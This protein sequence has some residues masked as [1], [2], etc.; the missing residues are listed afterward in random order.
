MLCAG[1]ESAPAVLFP[2]FLVHA[3]TH[4]CGW[5]LLFNFL[6]CPGEG[7]RG[8]IQ[9]R[10]RLSHP[11]FLSDLS[12]VDLVPATHGGTEH[13]LRAH[14]GATVWLVC[15]A[16]GFP[17]IT[18]SFP[19]LAL[20]VCFF[21]RPSGSFSTRVSRLKICTS[22]PQDVVCFWKRRTSVRSSLASS[23][24]AMYFIITLSQTTT[25]HTIP[26]SFLIPHINPYARFRQDR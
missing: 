5:F 11:S 1:R 26:I 12:L 24:P 10:I 8:C 14:G 16:L 19:A 17:I 15:S 9:R 20:E 6:A 7:G 18:V 13:G 21:S 2:M 3:R 25:L 22:T 23:H 4:I